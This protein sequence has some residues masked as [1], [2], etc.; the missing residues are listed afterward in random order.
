MKRKLFYFVPISIAMTAAFLIVAITVAH[1]GDP[2][3]NRP[4]EWREK[5][6]FRS[7]VVFADDVDLSDATLS[8][9]GKIED[10]M[11]E[12]L[13]DGEILIGTDGTAANNALVT[14]SGDAALANDGTLTIADDAVS[15]AKMGLP[16]IQ[17]VQFTIAHDDF[18]AEATS[19]VIET[20][21]SIPK[22]AYVLNTLIDSVT[23]FEG[24]SISAATITIG[25][26]DEAGGTTAADR[27][28][29]GTPDVFQDIDVLDAGAVSGTAL[30]TS[31]E[32]VTVTLDLTAGDCDETTAGA[33][34]VT[35]FYLQAVD[36]S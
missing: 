16:N 21:V 1:A 24:A 32:T 20:A 28:N 6:T 2:K 13:A 14:M 15:S 12:A 35:I 18:T 22:G 9:T 30:H 36:H 11:F 27:Y 33:A 34:T 8:A 4:N 29:T 17:S 26:S 10:S 31:A 25:D 3:L 5:N 23:K 7:N 19:E